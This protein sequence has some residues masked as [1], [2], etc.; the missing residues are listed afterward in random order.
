M[1]GSRD[2]SL[3]GEL[4]MSIGLRA[5]RAIA[6]EQYHRGALRILRPHYL[7]DGDQVCYVVVNPGGAYLGGD[8][9]GIDVDVQPE[10]RLLLTTQS[11]TKIYRTPGSRARQDMRLKLAPGSA[12][13]FMP[14][15]LI[16]YEGA[17]YLQHTVVEMD[18]TAS[19]VMAEVVTPGWSPDGRLFR[20]DTVRLRTDIWVDGRLVVLDNL[21]I[22][23][24]SGSPVDGMAFME[25]YTH[26]GS[27]LVIDARVDAALVEELHALLAP[28]D[29]AGQ[30]GISLLEGP[31]LVVR[32]LSTATEPLN[33]LI[34]AAGDLL[35]ARW[36][37]QQPLNLRKY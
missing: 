22:T 8:R 9:Y 6:T 3:V 12:V 33:A 1:P 14:D 28:M 19:L 21:Q 23:P 37:G 35:R 27:L 36:H 5:G 34:G 20:Y 31:G 25:H 26:L 7:D 17:S 10:A 24:G 30:L 13:E 18:S 11:A 29:P 2:E 4:R 16:A 32:A 15:Q